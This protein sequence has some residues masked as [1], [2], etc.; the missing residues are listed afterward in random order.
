MKLRSAAAQGLALGVAAAAL[1]W[2]GRNAA[3][4]LGDRGISIGFGFLD[5]PANFEVGDAPIAYDPS[6]SFA[7]ALLV[8]LANTARVSVL[9]WIFAIALGFV[10]G[11][12]RLSTN[13]ALR[14]VTRAFFNGP[15][16]SEICGPEFTPDG[17]TLFLAIQH[18]GD[19]SSFDKPSTR[20]PDFR[21]DLPPRGSVVPGAV[22]RSQ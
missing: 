8:G 2:L 15:R 21:P 4:T 6:N 20:W 1:W 17:R 9:G 10:L 3:I 22:T 16:G 14:G 13:P 11:I 7:R 19:G 5:Q 18:P 12:A